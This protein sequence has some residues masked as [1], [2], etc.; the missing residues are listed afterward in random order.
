MSGEDAA[1]V[2]AQKKTFTKWFN[3][4]LRKKGYPPIENIQTDWATGIKLMQVVNALYDIPMPRKYNKNPKMRPH[5]LD[6]ISMAM[7]MLEEK[8]EVKTNFLKNSH[9]L[10][11]D[12]KMLLGMMWSII[13]HYAING[14]N[15]DDLN[16]KEGLL[17][18]VQ[19]KTKGYSGVDPP[20][21]KNFHRDWRN[22]LA[23]CALIHR[24]YPNELD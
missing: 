17:L 6:N 23:F 21:V 20:K 22:G 7:K 11:G 10:D 14:I 5:K 3:N 12:E 15:V 1:W 18:W 16:A 8:A 2:G 13:L 4:H 19:K 24:H 9:L